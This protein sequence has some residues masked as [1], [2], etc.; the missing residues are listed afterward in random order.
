[1]LTQISPGSF[2]DASNI[3]NFLNFCVKLRPYE[4]DDTL[5]STCFGNF[6]HIFIKY[7]YGYRAESV[8]LTRSFGSWT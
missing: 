7:Q 6:N 2:I 1:M 8:E 5:G 4:Y 3:D